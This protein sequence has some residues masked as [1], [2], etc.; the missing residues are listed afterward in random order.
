MKT[1]FLFLS[2]ACCSL[3]SPPAPFGSGTITRSSDGSTAI[4]TRYGNGTRTVIT[5][6][7]K[8]TTSAITTRYGNGTRT[9]VTTPGK[10]TQTLVTSRYG[11]KPQT[12]ASRSSIH[13]D[14]S[15]SIT[16]ARTAIQASKAA[17]SIS[18]SSPAKTLLSTQRSKR[19][20]IRE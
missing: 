13:S 1:L 19:S 3:A 6:P 20:V 17:T 8:A 16:G 10:P 5:T 9:V 15:R 7:G 12:S 14:R 4:T 11:L 18:P 2:L